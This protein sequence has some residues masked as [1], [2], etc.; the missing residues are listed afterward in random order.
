MRRTPRIVVTGTG[1][2]CAAGR[3]PGEIL[4]A[5][6]AGRSAIAPIR[7]WD[8][9]GWPTRAAGEIADFN[10]AALIPDRKLHKLIRRTDLLGLYAAGRAIEDSGLVAYRDTLDEGRAA[11]CND[12]AGVY[13]GAGG[14]AFQNQYDFFPLLSAAQ[15]DLGAFGRELDGT[16]NPMWLLRS[17]PNNVLCHIGIRYGLKGAN[18]CV[19]NHALSG[20]LAVVEAVEAL[21]GNEADR[22]V[23]V[24][25][26]APIEPQ[27]VLYYARTGLFAVDSLRPF[28]AGRTGSLFGEGAGALIVETEAAAAERRAPVLGEILG[29]G[30]AAESA[31]L[32]AI[33]DDGEGIGRAITLALDDAGV[34]AA[35]VGM[36]VAHGNGT[37]KSDASEAAAIRRVF[38]ATP[39]PITAFK[40]A[41]G[42]LIAASGAIEAVLTLAAL[43]NGVVPGV[44]NLQRL[45]PEFGEL[46]ISARPQ[47]PR[48]DVG[49]VLSRGFGGTNAALL[50]RAARGKTD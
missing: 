5:V 25:H 35:E 17:L 10:A 6:H 44:A 48:S 43:R 49:L 38:G 32:F 14:G 27:M 41:F 20:I 31:G 4:D 30:V 8:A 36:I 18:A 47:Q 19:T 16:V 11:A 34:S 24:G 21:R 33:R 23:A 2:I 7:Q 15:G 22:A 37:L 1:A 3:T 13:A 12:R 9:S 45:D 28:D 42:H 40:W 26:D 46:P 39:P 50:V 29:S